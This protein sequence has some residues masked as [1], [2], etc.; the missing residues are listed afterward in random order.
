MMPV[1]RYSP[2]RCRLVQHLRTLG[3]R[4]IVEALLEVER[5]GS[6]DD[7]LS[8]FGRLHIDALCAAG[9]HRFPPAPLTLIEGGAR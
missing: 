1:D 3:D 5:G 6:V 8:E 9:G 7:V 2:Q 4:A